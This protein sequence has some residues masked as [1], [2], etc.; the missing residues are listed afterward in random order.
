M[1]PPRRLAHAFVPLWLV[2]SAAVARAQGA[3][4]VTISEDIDDPKVARR[5]GARVEL[6]PAP[7]TSPAAG[8]ASADQLAAVAPVETVATPPESGEGAPARPLTPRLKL[9]YRHFTFAQIGPTSASGAGADEPFDV[10]S[11]DLYPVSSSW[12]FGF[13][14][15]YAWEAG[16]F[17]QG[18]DAFIAESVSLGG[19][20]PG[21]VATPFFEAYAGGGYMQRTHAGLN[22]VATIYGQ[23]GLDAGL[24]IFLARYFCLSVALGYIHP[25]NG[26][27]KNATYGSF[28]VDT[29]S[30]KLGVGL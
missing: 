1:C 19:Q 6:V 3:G 28:S 5:L 9:G 26:F 24:E 7:Q 4:S 22:S 14:T 13:S 8:G 12:R 17:R 15:Q 23:L 18:G 2:A 20:I 21:P 25:S 29:W 30:F 11:L 16:T 10:L 27:V